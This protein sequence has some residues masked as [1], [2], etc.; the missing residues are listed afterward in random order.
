MLG[1]NILFLQGP[2]GP[3]F[4]RLADHLSARGHATHKINFNGGD[5]LFGRADVVANYAGQPQ[6]WR[7][8]LTAFLGEHRISAIFLYG[9]C[10]FYHRIACQLASELDIAIWVFEEGYLRPDFVTLESQGVNC[11][12]L[13][14]CKPETIS[15]HESL[16]RKRDLD[17]G[18]SF[19]QR[20][21]YA[22]AYYI[23][24]AIGA[25]KFRHYHHHRRY[26]CLGEATRWLR[27]GYR[28]LTCKFSERKLM[29]K[30]LQRWKGRYYLVPLQVHNDSQ[31]LYHS[32]FATVEAM[33]EHVLISFAE[34]APGDHALVLKHHPIDRGFKHYGTL[35]N[36]LA[37]QLGIVDRVISCHDLHL[38][39]LYRHAKGAVTVNSTVGISCLIHRLPVK[40]LG[41]AIYDIAGLT[42][43]L[44]LD[45]FWRETGTV[46][47]QLMDDFHCYLADKTQIN[48]SFYKHLDHSCAAVLELLHTEAAASSCG[49]AAEAEAMAA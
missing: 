12:S 8:F 2:L 32:D 39:T 20:A 22:S 4:T 25:V 21:G 13:L 6:D 48:G 23:L 33:I 43:Q 1:K 42:S 44:P 46:D 27:G 36:R 40:V 14:D 18:N 41:R 29:D 49:S 38:P 45:N 31:I 37:R 47:S 9:D 3:F 15:A 26:S 11:R 16:A 5:W 10:R 19:V 7:A 34:H 35:V 28:K 24:R 30:L 17:V